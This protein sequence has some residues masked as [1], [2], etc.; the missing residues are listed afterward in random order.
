MVCVLTILACWA[1]EKSRRSY[2]SQSIV[3][4]E[5]PAPSGADLQQSPQS[6]ARRIQESSRQPILDTISINTSRNAYRWLM[7]MQFAVLTFWSLLSCT[8]A[9]SRERERGTWDFQ[10]TT[11][12]TSAELLIGKLL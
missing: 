1:N 6:K 10:R 12:L 7:L 11:R 3:I 5:Q 9:V 2:T 4:V 8:Q